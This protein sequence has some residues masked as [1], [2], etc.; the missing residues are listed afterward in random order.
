MNVFLAN[1]SLFNHVIFMLILTNDSL[2]PLKSIIAAKHILQR[3]SCW[4][5]GNGRNIRVLKDAWIPNYNTNKVLHPTPNIE[6]E[7][8]VAE[9][10]D[11]ESRGWDRELIWQNFHHEDAEAILR[12]P[13][14]FRDIPDIVVWSG[15]KSGVYSVKLRYREAQKAWRELNWAECSRGAV[16]REV[17]KSLWKLKL[18]NK[19]KVFGWR[20]CRCILPTRVNLSKKRIIADNRCEACKTELETEIHAI[21]NC[22][23]AQDIW[24]GCSRRLQKC[25]MGPE[26]MMRL[27]EELTGRLTIDELE[28]FLVQAWFI[29]N[30]R[31]ALI[32]GKRLQELGILNRRAEDYLAEFRLAHSR[33]ATSPPNSNPISWRPP[34]PNRFKLNF[35][36][37]MFKE[38]DASGFRAIIRNER[39]EVMAALSG[40]GP[41]AA[42]SEEAEVLACRRAVEFTLECGFREMVVEGDNQSVMAA[43]ERKSCLLSRVGHILQD[44]LYMVN[45]FRWSQVQFAKRSANTIAHLLARHAKN[46]THDVIWLEDSPPPVVQALYLDSISI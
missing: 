20:A 13:S 19:I 44:I 7:M 36:A 43:L 15:E 9:L 45:E 40:K 32:H 46:V 12:V 22:G 42:C 28:L 17:W 3:G 33:L 23:V 30:Q 27:W 11:L 2:I 10:I 6:D 29:W 1:F 35:D 38:E 25:H 37:A 4:R 26:D 21:W 24:A 39:G 41:P 31:N 5:V 8:T 14:S 16:G 18:P 34:P